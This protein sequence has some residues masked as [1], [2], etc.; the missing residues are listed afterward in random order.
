MRKMSWWRAKRE[1][2]EAEKVGEA[3]WRG[4]RDAIVV[5]IS[6]SAMMHVL[7][8]ASGSR[9]KSSRYAVATARDSAEGEVSIWSHVVYRPSDI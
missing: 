4:G 7:I 6:E 9:V 1:F 8:R 5:S 2:W 3:G